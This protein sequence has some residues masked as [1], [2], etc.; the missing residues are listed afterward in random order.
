M[1]K[2]KY[3]TKTLDQARLEAHERADMY[4]EKYESW[5]KVIPQARI[6]TYRMA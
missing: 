5:R 1:S 4:K 3:L 6:M 2:Y